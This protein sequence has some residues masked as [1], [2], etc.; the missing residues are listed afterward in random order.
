M[1]KKLAVILIL[2][3]L[4]L[5][6]GVLLVDKTLSFFVKPISTANAIAAAVI[7]VFFFGAVLLLFGLIEDRRVIYGTSLILVI[8]F[9][10]VGFRYFGHGTLIWYLIGLVIFYF[11]LVIAFE[12][13]ATEKDLYCKVS[14]IR[15]CRRGIPLLSIGLAI[16]LSSIYFVHPLIKFENNKITLPPQLIKWTIVPISPFLNKI[17]PFCDSNKTLDE[18][19][20]MSLAANEFQ[21]SLDPNSINLEKF[22]DKKTG[23]I[24]FS[25]L[26]GNPEIN[27]TVLLQLSQQAK[28][29][30]PNL[31]TQMR[32]DM[33][34][35][36]GITL[37]GKEK[38]DDIL[39]TIINN[40]LGDFIGPYGKYISY[41]ILIIVFLLAKFIFSFLAG[42]GLILTQII[43]YVFRLIDVV[44]IE[45]E[46]KEAEVIKI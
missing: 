30:N 34:Q 6:T 39:T 2:S 46:M 43:F 37:T 31:I 25:A 40:R 27:Q 38:M 16:F 36:L 18:I 29:I 33:G 8:V 5:L 24:D 45:K 19:L 28:K 20:S 44:S 10:A 32:V 11:S 42:I 3:F 26:A 7:A 41:L 23:K 22:V 14:L 13:I 15:F 35:S 21:P 9:V 4:F 17:L 12:L 1:S